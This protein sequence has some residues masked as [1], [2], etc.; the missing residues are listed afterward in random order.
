MAQ[1]Y[2]IDRARRQGRMQAMRNAANIL[3]ELGIG[4]E[5]GTT[6]L[7]SP[8]IMISDSWYEA[9]AVTAH[10]LRNV[11]MAVQC[12]VE[13]WRRGTIKKD[14]IA[15]HWASVRSASRRAVRLAHEL[16]QLCENA[17]GGLHLKRSRVDLNHLVTDAASRW[18]PA[19]KTAGV[20][21]TLTLPDQQLWLEADPEQLARVLDNLLDNAAKYTDRA[22]HVSVVLACEG[23][24]VALRIIDT[25][26]GI[27]HDF[28]PYVFDLFARD[29]NPL[30]R[31]RPGSGIGLMAVRRIIEM[32][33]GRVQVASPGPGAGSEFTIR[34]QLSHT[35]TSNPHPGVMT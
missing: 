8:L 29:Q 31:S 23:D 18:S 24:E 2:N 33:G 1:A 26:V 11:L 17:D 7:G 4:Q 10:D 16:A 20:R 35:T 13:L 5:D 30:V 15:E 27:A 3:F 34:L 25:G 6:C 9:L 12:T 14:A 22:G 21:F 32:H 28:L 19:F